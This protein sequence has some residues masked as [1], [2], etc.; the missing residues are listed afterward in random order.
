MTAGRGVGEAATPAEAAALDLLRLRAAAG[1]PPRD[2]ARLTPRAQRAMRVAMATGAPML[3]A[4]DAAAAAQ[5]DLAATRRAIAVASA[6]AKAV[7]GGLIAAP[8]VLVPFLGGIFGADL[9]A[10]YGTGPGRV[11]GAIGLGLLALGAA[12]VRRLVRRVGAPPRT[13]R[14]PLARALQAGI[15]AVVLG[16]VTT[17]IVGVAVGLFAWHRSRTTAATDPTTDEAAELT[18]T[19][20]TAGVGPG[21]A[22]RAA[23]RQLPG[24]AAGLRALALELELGLAAEPGGPL[25]RLGH[26]LRA[27]TDVGAPAAPALRRLAAEVRADERARVLAAA[28]RLPAQLTFPTALALLPATLL[29][30]GAPIVQVGLQQALS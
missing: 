14:T 22:L 25:A 7:A 26:V 18:A 8:F 13:A 6:Q 3:P 28:E 23:A 1:L 4:L 16:L 15:V 12:A 11:V 19:A 29:L 9:A 17:T 27:A 5:D 30:V 24:H 2:L 10:F 21:E 20:L